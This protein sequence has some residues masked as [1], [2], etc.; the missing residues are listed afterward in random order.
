MEDLNLKPGHTYLIRFGSTDSLHEVK[1]LLAT[2]KAYQVKWQSG[3]ISWELKSRMNS[4]YS[5][6]EDITILGKDL[7]FD[8]L[9]DNMPELKAIKLPHFYLEETCNICGGT[10]QVQNFETTAGTKTCPAC[11]GGGKKSKKVVLSFD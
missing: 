4:D 2:D 8:W 3:S 9:K 6:V 1:V 11:N 10:G 7:P 5:V